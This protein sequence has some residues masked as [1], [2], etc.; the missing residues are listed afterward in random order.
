MDCCDKCQL[1]HAGRMANK[2][3]AA[4]FEII[5]HEELYLVRKV[6]HATQHIQVV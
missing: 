6:L 1:R 5:A 2:F 3:A 4:Y